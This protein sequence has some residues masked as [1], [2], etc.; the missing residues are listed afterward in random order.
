MTL[1]CVCVPAC[2]IFE[3]VTLLWYG[4]CIHVHQIPTHA[5]HSGISPPDFVLAGIYPGV[6]LI[7]LARLQISPYHALTPTLNYVRA[8][9][10]HDLSKP[11]RRSLVDA[12]RNKFIDGT[13][14]S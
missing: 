7:S 8:T 2:L 10:S 13:L 4:H 5:I 12:I 11:I 14:G 3:F 9:K 1:L 6:I